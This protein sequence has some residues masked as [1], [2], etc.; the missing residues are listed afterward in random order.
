VEVDTH[1][2]DTV[3]ALIKQME[4]TFHG[5]KQLRNYVGKGAGMHML[6]ILIEDCDAKLSEIKQKIT[7]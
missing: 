6:E 1:N 7:Q 3:L 5:L 2:L 4:S